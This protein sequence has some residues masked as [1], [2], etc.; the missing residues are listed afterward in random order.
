M[1]DCSTSSTNLYSNYENT[2][3]N[4]ESSLYDDDDDHPNDDDDHMDTDVDGDEQDMLHTLFEQAE[5]P[6]YKDC[7]YMK[8]DVVLSLLNMKLNGGWSDS[9]FTLLLESL[10]LWFPEDNALPTSTY[11]A[12]KFMCPMGLEVQRIHACPNN[13]MLFRGEG[14]EKKHNCVKCGASRYKR[15]KDTDEVDDEVKKNGPSTKV[16]LY[17]PIIPRLQRLF[18]NP[19]EA[20]SL[21]WHAERRKKDGKMRHVADSP[22]WRNIDTRYP[23]FG[24]E[25]RNIRFGLSSDGINPFGNMSSRHSTW[26]V[27]LCI[28]NLPTW[29]C[30]KRKYIM[31][32]LLIQ[33]PKQPGNDIDVYLAPLIDDLK[34]LWGEG[35]DVYDAY[36][37]EHFQLR[38]M[39]FVL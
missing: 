20:K 18:S 38:A 15:K 34:T 21:C 6:L 9:S 23:D 26:P 29:L 36:R 13:C 24:K 27:L 17:L 31:M 30:M 10:K 14:F 2:F 35:V 39:L 28:Y 3:N 33:G 7:K 37:K 8:L 16:L 22:Q 32:S 1:I 4:N 19:K 25:M 11:Q 12:K 5:I